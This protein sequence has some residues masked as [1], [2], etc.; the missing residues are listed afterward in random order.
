MHSNDVLQ[1]T[2]TRRLSPQTTTSSGYHSDLSSTNEST[3]GITPTTTLEQS[4]SSEIPKKTIDNKSLTNK[5]L[6]RIS[7]F[8][9][10][11][12]ERAKTK[13]IPTKQRPPAI[14]TSSK[15]TSITPLPHLTENNYTKQQQHYLSTI[16]QQSS[17]IEPSVYE[18][19]AKIPSKNDVSSREYYSH[20]PS[21]RLSINNNQ[22]NSNSHHSCRRLAAMANY[23]TPTDGCLSNNTRRHQ[24]YPV[25]PLSCQNYY[26]YRYLNN[27]YDSNRSS[28]APLSDFLSAKNSA[29]KPV[30]RKE[31]YQRPL[32][33][34]S[35]QV[36]PSDDP[37]DLEVAQ[38]FH[39]TSQW[40]NPNYFDV[41]TIPKQNYAETLC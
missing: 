38:Y 16:Y 23:Q 28:Y 20:Q 24:Y 12:Y 30:K 32:Y 40:S 18:H 13:L 29:F 26:P 35:E 3:H 15:A 11:Q 34:M 17:F 21:H 25:K 5:N 6:S 7:S 10:K 33:H 4:S 9:R 36:P 31:F 8:I 39:Q 41:Y 22:V 27:N 19:Q 2:D 37:C 1:M 14:T